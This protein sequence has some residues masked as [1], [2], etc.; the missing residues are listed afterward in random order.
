MHNICIWVSCVFIRLHPMFV[1]FFI[2][3]RFLLLLQFCILHEG[4]LW[5]LNRVFT[6]NGC[7]IS[8]DQLAYCSRATTIEI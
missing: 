2:C 6:H 1:V 5:S 4:D 3:A 8:L 7:L